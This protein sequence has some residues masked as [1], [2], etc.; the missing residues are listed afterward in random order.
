MLTRPLLAC[1]LALAC[2]P[3]SAGAPIGKIQSLLAKPTTVCGRFE[4]TRQLAGLKK[5]L[6]SSGRFCLVA[7]KG[8]LWRTLQPFPNTLK[9]TRDEI[10]QSQNERIAVR[11]D[12]KQEPA[13]RLI[14][15]V[16][17]SLLAG[18]VT[19][20]ESLFEVDG[21]LRGNSWNVVL[22]PHE[23]ALTKAVGSIVLDGDAYVRSITINEPNGDR[24]SIRFADIVTGRTAFDAEERA[25]L[26]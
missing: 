24:S 11:L 4:Q 9:V 16:L 13:V 18:D 20:L 3:S 14:N 5:P 8:V 17:L 22:K 2:L 1:C 6:A 23:P 10:V 7:D 19:Q 25:L 12:A 21:T 15:S 26:E